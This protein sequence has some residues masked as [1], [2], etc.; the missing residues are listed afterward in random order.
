M[1]KLIPWLFLT[2]ASSAFALRADINSDGRVD[3][4]D[5]LI[6]AEEWLMETDMG[7][8]PELVTNGGF[9][10]DTDWTK[11]TGWSVDGGVAIWSAALQDVMYQRLASSNYTVY[12]VQFDVTDFSYVGANYPLVRFGG[13]PNFFTG[14]G[15]FSFD[16]TTED[17]SPYRVQFEGSPHDEAQTFKI[18]NVSVKK[19]IGGAGAAITVFFQDR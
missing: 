12:R 6:L 2:C 5:F 9:D 11:G 3:L 17:E 19:V 10:A 14:N 1:Q 13:T 18:D 4:W 8:G 15:H 7:L 16:I